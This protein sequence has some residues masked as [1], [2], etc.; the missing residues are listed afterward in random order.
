MWPLGGWICLFDP[1]VKYHFPALSRRE[2]YTSAHLNDLLAVLCREFRLSPGQDSVH[3]LAASSV[4]ALRPIRRHVGVVRR[5]AVAIHDNRGRIEQHRAAAVH[6][7]EPAAAGY[8]EPLIF[9]DMRRLNQ[10]VVGLY[11]F[12]AAVFV[13]VLIFPDRDSGA[14]DFSTVLNGLIADP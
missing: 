8:F 9:R 12:E 6:P 1:T 11:D 2:F 7:Y 4:K 13:R 5:D 14:V 10:Y 3:E